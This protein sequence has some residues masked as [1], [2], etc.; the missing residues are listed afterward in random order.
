MA[1]HRQELRRSEERHR[2]RRCPSDSWCRPRSTHAAPTLD[3][4]AAAADETLAAMA[5]DPLDELS[6]MA[7]RAARPNGT[8]WEDAHD[9][10]YRTMVEALP[11]ITVPLD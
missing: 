1:H 9:I 11:T 2:L 10:A 6:R 5:D 4:L 3:G 7:E 8:T